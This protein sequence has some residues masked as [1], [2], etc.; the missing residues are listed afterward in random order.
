MPRRRAR[1]RLGS[2]PERVLGLLRAAQKDFCQQLGR[3]VQ[4]LQLRALRILRLGHPW[5]TGFT[6][7]R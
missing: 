2:P 5:Q 4:Q 6:E 7:S 1:G 3:H